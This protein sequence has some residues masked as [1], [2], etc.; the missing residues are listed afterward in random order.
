[1]S[2]NIL[3]MILNNVSPQFL[4]RCASMLGI[5]RMITEK[6]MKAAVPAV[7][8][9][10]ARIAA[11]PDG[12]RQLDNAVSSA[13]SNWLESVASMAGG[14][15][16]QSSMISN[17]MNILSSLLGSDGVK[18]ISDAVGRYAGVAPGQASSL[19]GLSGLLALSGLNKVQSENGL[20]ASGLAQRLMSQAP[21]FA[22]A[23]PSGFSDMLRG[24]E[25]PRA[26]TTFAR[27]ATDDARRRA[28]P[29][30]AAAGPSASPMPNWL[31]WALGLLAVLAL[32][33]LLQPMFNRPQVA[34]GPTTA[35]PPGQTTTAGVPKNAAGQPIVAIGAPVY[36]SDGERLGDVTE[37]VMGPNNVVEG[38]KLDVG[39]TLGIGPK[40]VMI[41]VDRIERQGDRLVSKVTAAEARALP[42]APSTK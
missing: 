26:D 21:Q 12:A 27:T 30:R 5:D 34:T 13:P 1:M 41:N 28:A 33:W 19:T 17:G 14:G 9:G 37:V 23:M 15:S 35:P 16:G 7:L 18:T 10:I 38:V 36:S 40:T 11:K 25:A 2:D 20:D 8:A 4:G 31:Y 42:P 29:Q 6:A 24:A 32:A 22:A 39:S 3:S